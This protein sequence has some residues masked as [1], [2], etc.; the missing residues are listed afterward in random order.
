MDNDK[1]LVNLNGLIISG[2]CLPITP[3]P[4]T[5]PYEYCFVSGLTYTTV[6][7]QC[8]NDGLIY[9]DVY[10]TLK[11]TSTIFGYHMGPGKPCK[12]T[13]P[14]KGGCTIYP[15][16]PDDPCKHFKCL[17]NKDY[18][19][20]EAFKPNLSKVILVPRLIE[21]IPYTV[22]VEAG[23]PLSIEVLDWVLR[24]FNEGKMDNII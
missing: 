7:F 16:R 6:P 11:L 10:G 20:P 8:P 22:V 21:D 24:Q 13:N 19:I 4:S 9:Y 3:T 15:Y 23:A 5:T 12:F 14:G 17:W 1:A 18:T 2:A